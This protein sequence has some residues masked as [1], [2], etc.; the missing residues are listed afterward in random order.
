MWL[1][2]ITVGVEPTNNSCLILL[3]DFR[4]CFLSSLHL[5]NGY[6]FLFVRGF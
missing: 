1:F 6:V 2:V 4:G 5:L 3:L